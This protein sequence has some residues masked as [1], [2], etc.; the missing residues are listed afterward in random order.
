MQ[1]D[2]FARQL[3]E[4]H[5]CTTNVEA[6]FG[7]LTPLFGFR[8]LGADLEIQSAGCQLRGS[9]TTN[10]SKP[11]REHFWFPELRQVT[12]NDGERLLSYVLGK[13]HIA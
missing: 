10:R 7:C 8:E 3:V 9:V 12:A 5:Q 1:H 11:L 2:Y 6:I 13:M 4:L